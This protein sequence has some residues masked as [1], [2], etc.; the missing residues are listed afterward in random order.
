[1]TLEKPVTMATTSMGMVALQPANWNQIQTV[2][3]MM[4]QT[5]IFAMFVEIA[6]E[7]VQ[8]LVTTETD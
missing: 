6:R 3:S 4:I 7:K 8:K 2:L 1:M 5:L